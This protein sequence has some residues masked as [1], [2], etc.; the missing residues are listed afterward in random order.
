MNPRTK[1][2]LVFDASGSYVG[3]YCDVDQPDNV[4]AGRFVFPTGQKRTLKPVDRR[5]P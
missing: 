4:A 3:N 5:E 2:L 1:R